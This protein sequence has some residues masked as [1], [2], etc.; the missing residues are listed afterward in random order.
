MAIFKK[1]RRFQFAKCLLT[2]SG[3]SIAQYFLY[4]AQWNT[5]YVRKMR[6]HGTYSY[7]AWIILKVKFTEESQATATKEGSISWG[8]PTLNGTAAGLYVDDSDKLRY[9]LHKTFETASAAKTWINSM[10]NV[11]AGT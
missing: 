7:E 2:G 9:Q 8:T 3:G 10:L 6:D 11:S 5:G 4:S 1:Q